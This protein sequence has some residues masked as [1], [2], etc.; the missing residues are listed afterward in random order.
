[1]T[2][3]KKPINLSTRKTWLYASLAAA[4]LTLGACADKEPAATEDEMVVDAQTSVEQEATG[5]ANADAPNDPMASEDVAVASDDMMNEDVAVA[6][7]E[8]GVAVGIDD[9]EMLDGSESEEHVS[10]Y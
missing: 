3:M 6:S 7:A 8:D 10:T 9:S 5:V 4:A 2:I 1:M